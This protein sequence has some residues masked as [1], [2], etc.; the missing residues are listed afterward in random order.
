MKKLLILSTTIFL[1]ACACFNSSAADED[2]ATVKETT[3]VTQTTTAQPAPVVYTETA[4]TQRVVRR[5]RVYNEAPEA[6]YMPR[7][8]RNVNRI[9]Y[10][11]YAPAP[12][13]RSAPRVVTRSGAY[14]A[15]D[16]GCAP[17]VRETREPVEVI[18]K[19]TRYTTVYRPETHTDVRYTREPYA[20]QSYSQE[21]VVDNVIEE[22]DY[23]K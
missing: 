19:N 22:D 13:Y 16:S 12:T 7:R 5:V 20:Q 11:G 3:T 10:D 6:E 8:A 1:S 23:I 4:P 21:V 2:N 9:Y 18:Y 15:C 17:K 14:D